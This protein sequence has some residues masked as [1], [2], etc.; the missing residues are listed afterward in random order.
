MHVSG[1]SSFPS[2]CMRAAPLNHAVPRKMLS[3]QHDQTNTRSP[4][5][6]Y[7]STTP[8][9]ILTTTPVNLPASRLRH[10]LGSNAMGILAEILTVDLPSLDLLAA[11]PSNRPDPQVPPSG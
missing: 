1:E 7:S 6:T 4:P 5:A 8:F 3:D 10:C 11:P 2:R 9:A